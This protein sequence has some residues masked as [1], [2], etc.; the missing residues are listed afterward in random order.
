MSATSTWTISGVRDALRTKEIS[1]R[2]LTK[3]SRGGH[4]RQ[5]VLPMVEFSRMAVA[6]YPAAEAVGERHPGPASLAEAGG[7]ARGAAEQ[8]TIASS[9]RTTA[10]SANGANAAILMC[11]A[12]IARITVKIAHMI[13]HA[14]KVWSNPT[15]PAAMMIGPAK[16]FRIRPVD[17]R[18]RS[19][20]RRRCRRTVRRGGTPTARRQAARQ[21][22]SRGPP[23]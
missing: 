6:R 2:E 15:A 12:P 20:R 16:D 11:R 17:S 8:P 10:A 7:P 22:R 23:R 13:S 19:T 1:A 4:E 18:N 9:T 21:R 5:P 3:D 14:A